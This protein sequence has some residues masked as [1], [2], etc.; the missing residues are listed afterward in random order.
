MITITVLVLLWLFYLYCR[1]LGDIEVVDMSENGLPSNDPHDIIGIDSAHLRAKRHRGCWIFVVNEYHQFLFVKRKENAKTCPSTWSVIGE[2][3]H[4]GESYDNCAKRA[5]KEEISVLK[6][7]NLVPMEESP[8]FFH[9]DYGARVDKQWTKLYLVT[10]SKSVLRKSDIHENDDFT[11][12]NF[13]EADHWLHQCP[14]GICRYCNPSK[15][16][17]M[18]ENLSFSYYYSFIEMTVEYLHMAMVKHENT[19]AT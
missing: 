15:V 5:L 1:G 16:W 9:L 10:V 4:P 18:S 19:T 2:H 3:T 8:V 14:N 11:W 7:N 6:Y 13:T 12:V 17:K